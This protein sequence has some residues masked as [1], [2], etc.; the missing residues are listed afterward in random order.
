MPIV[1]VCVCFFVRVLV[2][3]VTFLSQSVIYKFLKNKKKLSAYMDPPEGPQQTPN[4]LKTRISGMSY[5]F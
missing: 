3:P 1:W 4:L 5:D 2:F